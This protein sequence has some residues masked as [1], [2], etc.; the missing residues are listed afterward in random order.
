[1]DLIR[2][3]LRQSRVLVAFS[4]LMGLCHGAAHV[5]LLYLM[6][7]WVVG[8]GDVS[9]RLG[10]W[11]FALLLFVPVSKVTSEV[12]VARLAQQAIF[13]LRMELSRRLLAAPLSQLDRIGERFLKA[14]LT[15]DLQYVVGSLIQFPIM[16][17]N[18]AILL[19]SLVF[20]FAMS[21]KMTVAIVV[22]VIVGIWTWKKV[23]ARAAGYVELAERE[24]KT[25]FGHFSSLVEGVKELKL[26]P[27]LRERFLAERLAVAG[28]RQRR[29]KLGEFLVWSAGGAWTFFLIYGIFGAILFL[30]P[31]PLGYDYRAAA[32]FLLV[33]LF[34]LTPLDGLMNQ[35]IKVGSAT[36][37]YRRVAE[38]T[39]SLAAEPGSSPGWRPGI[40]ARVELAGVRIEPGDGDEGGRELGPLDLVLRPGELLVI[41]GPPGS[42]KTALAKLL[43]GLYTAAAGQILVD[44]RVVSAADLEGYRALCAGVFPG[45]ELFAELRPAAPER[46]RGDLAELARKLQ[47][48]GALGEDGRL[49]AGELT[50][51]QRRRLALLEAFALDR[52]LY[53][54]DEWAFEQDLEFR[55]VFYREYLSN[56]RERGKI[57]V[58]LTSEERYLDGADRLLRL[59]D[60]RLEEPRPRVVSA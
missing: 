59:S 1:M 54:F 44:G 13:D 20:L 36:R 14:S 47:I 19:A 30:L 6:S 51:P 52:F 3:L 28:D 49:A 9:P 25:L 56:L 58:V 18:F 60:G 27:G 42:G 26:D 45:S 29:Y 8:H 32:V 31:A 53:V 10:L 4:A 11:F 2:L 37:A 40:P 41:A 55:E 23:L 16:W 24:E 12:A 38:L 39:R 48:R 46:L 34:C 17:H 43:T 21:W 7:L 33:F 57:V 50:P 15:D 22:F 5:G 35:F